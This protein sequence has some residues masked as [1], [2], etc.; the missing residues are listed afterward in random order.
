MP[1]TKTSLKFEDPPPRTRNRFDWEKVANELRQ[2]PGE[3]ALI[4]KNFPASL[5]S[6]AYNGIKSFPMDE[7][8]L[9]TSDNTRTTPRTCTLHARYV[10]KKKKVK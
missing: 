2:H 6:S 8:E 9:S 3:W 4:A 1:N 7:F 5:V 10:G